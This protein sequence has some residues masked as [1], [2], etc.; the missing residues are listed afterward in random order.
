MS[1]VRTIDVANQDQLSSAI[2]SYVVQG[3][4][5]ANREPNVVTMVK[6]K[7]FNMVWAV[8]GFFLCILPLLVYLIVYSTQDDQ[9]VLIRVIGTPAGG[10][11][12]RPSGLSPDGRH[13]WDGTAWQ[14]VT[15]TPPATAQRSPDG[16]F[17]WDGAT[18]QPMPPP[19][20]GS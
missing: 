7:S 17:W 10:L 15:I 16:R 14:D 1:Q 20:V 11:A 13:W 12:P 4:A 19:A 9:V 8:I 3:F 2:N 18:W 5:V 6:P